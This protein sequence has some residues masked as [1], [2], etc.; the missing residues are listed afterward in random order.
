[1]FRRLDVRPKQDIRRFYCYLF[2]YRALA[3][4]AALRG[5]LQYLSGA[6]RRWK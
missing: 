5:Y 3:S 6:A 4:P 1:M 2:A